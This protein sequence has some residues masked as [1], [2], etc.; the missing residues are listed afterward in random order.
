VLPEEIAPCEAAI[1]CQDGGLLASG[2]SNDFVCVTGLSSGDVC[3]YSCAQSTDCA[4]ISESC[5]TLSGTKACFYNYCDNSLVGPFFNTC[6]ASGS[7]DGE[8]LAYGATATSGPF[9]AVCYQNGTVA[10]GDVCQTYRTGGS[11]DQQ[12]VF[13]QFCVPRP[14][15]Q[16]VGVCM[17]LSDTGQFGGSHT[18]PCTDPSNLVWQDVIGADF[19]VCVPPCPD[20]GGACPANLTCRSISGVGKGCVP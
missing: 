10:Q 20:D 9:G 8:C 15:D 6:D 7:G 13:G 14:A 5:Q 18:H 4:N 2:E 3:L 11:N 17:Q 16:T 1:G 19:G 12:C